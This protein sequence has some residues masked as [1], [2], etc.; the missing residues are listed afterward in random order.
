MIIIEDNLTSYNSLNGLS[1]NMGRVL[2]ERLTKLEESTPVSGGSC[3][4]II[5]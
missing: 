4:L 3:T 2:N 1:A 5:W